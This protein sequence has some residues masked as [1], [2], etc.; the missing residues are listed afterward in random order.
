MIR[1]VLF[2]KQCLDSWFR[3]RWCN[4]SFAQIGPLVAQCQSVV[5]NS[6]ATVTSVRWQL[7][8]SLMKAVVDVN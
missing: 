4:H 1:K 6:P 3:R 7:Y 2:Q 5:I 8:L